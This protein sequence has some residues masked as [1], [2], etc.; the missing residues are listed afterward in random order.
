[1]IVA[2][3]LYRHSDLLCI[4][5]GKRQNIFLQSYLE[6]KEHIQSQKAEDTKLGMIF[7]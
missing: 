2:T 4:V 5:E 6:R 7:F 3:K 1:M